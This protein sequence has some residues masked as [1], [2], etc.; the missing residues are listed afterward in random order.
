[1][2]NNSNLITMKKIYLIVCIIVTLLFS[3]NTNAQQLKVLNQSKSSLSLELTID[4]YNIKEIIDGDEVF[5]EIALSSIMIPNY[6]GKPNLPS[7]NRFV[8]LPQGAKANVV[9]ES[10]EK[11]ILKNINIAPSEGIVSEYELTDEHFSKDR[12][13]YS[14]DEL[15]PNNIVSLTEQMNLRGIDAVGL[16][17]APVQF[18]PVSKEL[19]VYKKIKFRVEFEGGNGMFGDDRLRSM[20][21]DPILQ[22][23]ILNYNNISEIDYA[24]R[25]ER[26]IS[27]DAEGA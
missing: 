10:Y 25:M 1:M 22:H 23:N 6:K 7:V 5:H 13:I 15:Y 9:V 11:E 20:Y 18:N 4:N 16:S 26:W 17:I 2:R 24:K 8:A 3:N 19:I 27:D 14:K 12:N 21:W